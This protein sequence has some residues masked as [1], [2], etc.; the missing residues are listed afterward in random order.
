MHGADRSVSVPHVARTREAAPH[1]EVNAPTPPTGSAYWLNPRSRSAPRLVSTTPSS[2][3]R[4]SRARRS[5]PTPSTASVVTPGGIAGP[6]RCPSGT[7]AFSGNPPATAGPTG[8]PVGSTPGCCASEML[9][10]SPLTAPTAPPSSAS[11]ET[12]AR[13]ATAPGYSRSKETRGS[14]RSTVSRCP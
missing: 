1:R 7:A 5:A 9:K 2:V 14:R 13:A 3:S 11:R 4:S 12:G 6:K 10:K 8:A